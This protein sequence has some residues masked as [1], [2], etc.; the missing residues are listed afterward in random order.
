MLGYTFDEIR[1]LPKAVLHTHLDGSLRPDT[2]L[3]LWNGLPERNRTGLLATV[4]LAPKNDEQLLS[5]ICGRNVKAACPE[6]PLGEYLKSFALTCSTMQTG[7]ALER[8]AYEVAVDAWEDGCLYGEFRFAPFLHYVPGELSYEQVVEHV[9]MGLRR[10]EADTGIMTGL[11]ICG[12]RNYVPATAIRELERVMV[13]PRTE[14]Q[15]RRQQGFIAKFFMMEMGKLTESLSHHY[16]E[17]VGFDIAGDESAHP[18]ALYI[19]AFHTVLNNY[20]S[21]TAHA[22]EGFNLRSIEQAVNFAHATRLGHG[23]RLLDRDDPELVK[24]HPDPERRQ[25]YLDRVLRSVVHREIVFECCPTSNVQ[26]VTGVDDIEN[27]PIDE[28]SRRGVKV[29]VNPDNTLISD[30]TA[31][32]DLL[33]CANTFEWDEETVKRVCLN[34]F[35]RVFYNHHHCAVQRA[36]RKNKL[37]EATV[38]RLRHA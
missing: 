9:V 35:L 12:L 1:T 6:N 38:A 14:S 7:S 28:M 32:R 37:V 26:I 31:S 16:P 10:A 11:I 4:G 5:L 13:R 22:G 24:L 36:R 25:H 17:V 21:I 23:I 27:H 8:V 34:S 20:I 19:D 18:V 33:K 2:F 15:K 30:T 3:E 29:A